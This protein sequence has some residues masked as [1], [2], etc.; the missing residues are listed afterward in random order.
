MIMEWNPKEVAV[1][2][3][4]EGYYDNA[5]KGAQ[6]YGGKLNIRPEYQRE[7]V[8]PVDRQQAVIE[9]I[10]QNAPL[11]NIYWAINKDGTYEV[12]DGQQRIISIC[13]YIENRFSVIYKKEEY[14]FHSLTREEQEQI[15][16]YKLE[17]KIVE[18]TNREKL[19]WFQRVNIAG[20]ELTRQEVRNAIYTG[21]WLNSAR[22]YFSKA[23]CKI[24]KDYEKYMKGEYTRQAYLETAINWK[25]NGKIVDYMENNQNEPN[26]N[27]LQLY[28]KNVMNWVQASF[29]KYHEEMK[30]RPWGILYNKY[31]DDEL[32]VKELGDEITKLMLDSD[33]TN[34][35]GIYEYVLT[36]D[37]KYLSIRDF[38]ENDKRSVYNSQKGLCAIC[39]KSFKFPEMEGDHKL[40]WHEGGKTTAENCQMLCKTDNRIK[41]GK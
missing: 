34:K 8:Y 17:V 5:D 10:Q 29:P 11:N 33:V 36:R 20:L 6:G 2:E 14:Q 39:N 7:F 37:E 19:D 38:E 16:N 24:H 1:R 41:S 15:L 35:K 3:V 40:A 4:S 26:A 28:F 9:T 22:A 30:G 18:G 12:L 31:K 25:S 23:G 32:D 21:T 13:R 27:E